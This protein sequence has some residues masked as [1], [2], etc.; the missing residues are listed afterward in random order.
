VKSAVKTLGKLSEE[1][2][3]M[4]IKCFPVVKLAMALPAYFWDLEKKEKKQEKKQESH[5]DYSEEAKVEYADS[6]AA[7]AIL[8]DLAYLKGADG[9]IQTALFDSSHTQAS[10]NGKCPSA[11]LA[12]KGVVLSKDS[13]AQHKTYEA[14][15]GKPCW[16]SVAD[17]QKQ[18]VY[19]V[20]RGTA[21]VQDMLSDINI[22]VESVEL[23]GHPCKVHKGA[24]AA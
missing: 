17:E 1:M 6:D 22:Q 16:Y 8:A 4:G 14:G 21:N 13:F 11:E 12:S 23:C 18:V 15:I 20:V 19:V 9:K 5:F 3:T 24:S 2:D 10:M 7:M